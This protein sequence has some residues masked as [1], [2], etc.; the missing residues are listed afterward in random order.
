MHPLQQRKDG[1]RFKN[2]AELEWTHTSA[3]VE[4]KE[5]PS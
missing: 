2:R 4:D 3:F 1:P 5:S